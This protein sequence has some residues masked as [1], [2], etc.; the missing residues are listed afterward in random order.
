[1]ST[2]SPSWV[3]LARA[4]ARVALAVALAAACVPLAAAAHQLQLASDNKPLRWGTFP[5]TIKV[6]T[7]PAGMDV[8]GAFAPLPAI[9]TAAQQWQAIANAGVSVRYGGELPQHT[10]VDPLNGEV[11]VSF[12]GADFPG[13]G[14]ITGITK[15]TLD[16]LDAHRIVGAHV[17]LNARDFTWATSG[18]TDALDVQSVTLHELGHSLGIA[19]PCGDQNTAQQS[20]D[21]VPLAIRNQLELAVMWP[22]ITAGVR[23]T[24]AQDDLDAAADAAPVLVSTPPPALQAIAPSCV[25]GLAGNQFYVTAELQGSTRIELQYNGAVIVDAPLHTDA[26]G[27]VTFQVPNDTTLPAGLTSPAAIDLLLISDLTD[28]ADESIAGLHLSDTCA[29]DGCTHVGSSAWMLLGLVPF[30]WRRRGRTQPQSAAPR[31]SGRRAAMRPSMITGPL[32]VLLVLAAA[33]PARAYKRSV[34][35]GGLCTFW[36]TRGHSFMI[37]AKGTPDVPPAQ[38]FDAIRKS[39]QAW[40]GVTC[41]DLVFPDLGIS[42]NPS[43]RQTGFVA[44]GFNR[45][46]VMFRTANCDA[47]AVPAGDACLTEGGC[48]NKYDCWDHPSGIIATTTTTSNRFTGQIADSDIEVNDAKSSDGSKFTFTANDGP[49]CTDPSQV[50]CVHIDI[51]NTVTHEAGHSIGLDHSLDETATMYATAPEGETAKRNLH[52]D[53]IQAVCTIYPLGTAVVTCLGDPLTLTQT[54]AS[55]G[56]CGCNAQS[57]NAGAVLGLGLAFA[58]WTARRR[59]R[60]SGLNG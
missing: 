10:S 36:S 45:N 9:R 52:P 56:G 53:D 38:A 6:V 23:R 48:G 40:S 33:W 35:A 19:H 58:L 1:M 27:G 50:N 15:L 46:L 59:A 13:D 24:F 47:G 4:L 42:E 5:Q 34:N 49:P 44:D 39:F 16:P 54:G 14:T 2:V 55:D 60:H 28:K 29:T 7:P 57:N 18:A 25:K 22:R 20:C 37:D 26:T 43:D 32:A 41:R 12:D 51:R 11:I 31:R 21:S 8:R 17:H 3:R 30:L